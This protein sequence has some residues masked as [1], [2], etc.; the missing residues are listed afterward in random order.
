MLLTSLEKKR[1]NGNSKTTTHTIKFFDRFFRFSLFGVSHHFWRKKK[2]NMLKSRMSSQLR[3]SSSRSVRMEWDYKHQ[4]P[5]RTASK[6]ARVL[7]EIEARL[8][9]TRNEIELLKQTKKNL[10][11]KIKDIKSEMSNLKH[12]I[13]S[14]PN[15]VSGGTYE[16]KQNKERFKRLIATAKKKILF[17]TQCRD[18]ATGTS[19]DKT[20]NQ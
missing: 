4:C 12:K 13:C 17:A 16:A 15:Q 20:G 2:N 8:S 1:R 9:K 6:Q 14:V 7:E 5:K 3:P 19:S 10:R 11:N 18:T